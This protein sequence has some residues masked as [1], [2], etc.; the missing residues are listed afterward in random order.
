MQGIIAKYCF[1]QELSCNFSFCH[2][3]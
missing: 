3:Y 2:R 1:F